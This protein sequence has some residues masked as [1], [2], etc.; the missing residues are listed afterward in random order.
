M[1]TGRLTEKL[2]CFG[3]TG[4]EASVY[5]CLVRH[6]AQTG[7]EAARQTGISRSNAYS[8]LAGLVDKGA[9]Y[10][11]EGAAV[12][13]YAV[14]V[15]EFCSNKIRELEEIKAQLASSMPAHRQ[16]AEGYLTITGDHRIR[17][18][19]KNMICSARA[20]VY[21]SMTEAF[22]R[23]FER[24]MQQAAQDGKK[25]VLITDAPAVFAC[26]A[27]YQT[28]DRGAQIGLIADS[29]YVLTGEF[30]RGEESVCLYCGQK[31][32]VQVCKDS[33]RNEIQLIRLLKGESEDEKRTICNI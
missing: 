7:Y 30:G 11:Q 22:V 14:C 25:V 27:V 12:R 28:K 17:D 26:D 5:L 31:N 2:K 4:Q 6:G 9:A 23:L 1:D 10:A 13:Y 15:D 19:I 18:K 29:S 24:E 20:R 16:E 8:A 33:M 32:F 21:V 3:L